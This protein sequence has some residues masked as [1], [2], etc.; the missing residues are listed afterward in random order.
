M[1]LLDH[2]NVTLTL[3]HLGRVTCS[4]DFVKL[5]IFKK[6][7]RPKVVILKMS[8]NTKPLESLIVLYI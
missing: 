4:R 3:F 6:G 8:F 5:N 2:F 7:L 1:F